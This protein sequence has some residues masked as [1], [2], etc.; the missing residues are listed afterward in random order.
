MR[1]TLVCAADGVRMSS[2]ERYRALAEAAG[3]W[4]WETDA[5]G[6]ITASNDNVHEILGFRPD[7]VI[8]KTLLDLMPEAPRDDK[9]AELEAVVAARQPFSRWNHKGL[10]KDGRV[11]SL[12]TSGLPLIDE[13]GA[14]RGYA[15]VG[16]DL[17]GAIEKLED[18]S[19]SVENERR[20]T[21]R[22][23]IDNLA[24]AIF[25]ADAATERFVDAN[26]R[27]CQ[28]LGLTRDQLLETAISD[29]DLLSAQD[30]AWDDVVEA[31]KSGREVSYETEIR[32]SSG[33]AVPIEISARGIRVGAKAYMIASVRDITERRRQQE[34]LRLK[35]HAFDS[36]ETPIALTDL[37]G[38]YT[39]VNPAF[40][41]QWGYDSADEILG[42]TP[43][44]LSAVPDAAREEVGETRERG[45]YRG[46]TFGRRKDGTTFPHQVAASVVKDDLGRPV[47][48]MAWFPILTERHRIEEMLRASRDE[49]RSLT[50]NIPG[51]VFRAS[52]DWT[53][54]LVSKCE[55]ICGY[56]DD[57][58]KSAKV[59]WFDLIHPEDRKLVS[60]QSERL[61][62]SPLHLVQEY[63]I[64]AKDGRVRWVE[65]HKTPRFDDEGRF[66][67]VDGFVLDVSE[68][69]EAELGLRRFRDVMDRSSDSILVIDSERG[70]FIDLNERACE[71]LQYSR[72]ELLQM[73]VHDVEVNIPDEKAWPAYRE[74]LRGGHST[75]L[76]GI[77]RRRDG[78][79]FPVEVNGAL[80]KYGQ[81]E[82]IVALARDISDRRQAEQELRQTARVLDE[83][84]RELNC[85]YTI[86]QLPVSKHLPLEHMF[87]RII[88]IIPEAWQY[89]QLTCARL[90][91]GEQAYETR[92]FE[93]T[94]W[95][96]RRDLYAREQKVGTLEV[97]L[98]DEGLSQ[99]KKE[100]FV[101][102]QDLL[103]AIAD[104]LG[105]IVEHK[106][107]EDELRAAN[108]QIKAKA[109]ELKETTAQLIQT[110]KLSALGQLAAGVAHEMNQPLNGIKIISQDLLGDIR[111]NR[112]EVQELRANLEDVVELVNKLAFIIDQ[113]RLFVR[114][115]EH[116]DDDTCDANEAV[117]GVLKMVGQQL[118]DHAF[119]V[120][121]DLEAALPPARA[122]LVKI[123]QVL[124]NLITN[125]RDA[126]RASGQTERRLVV[127][128]RCRADDSGN[129]VVI[130]VQDNGTGID[131]SIRDRL[132][133]PFFTTKNAGEG[134]GL[135][136]SISHRIL[137]ECGGQ[138]EIESER[139]QGAVFRVIIPAVSQP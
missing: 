123:E 13:T 45:V 138:L 58:L 118:R 114:R 29:I 60:D 109:R 81:E 93:E 105:R 136:L 28:L 98:R 4:L 15:G 9:A 139:G 95:R 70:Q 90:Q 48:M 89:P 80:M 126:V 85:L 12:E 18:V 36:S 46:E 52:A 127:R 101:S 131:P 121:T 57:E 63:R 62:K 34:Q 10:C 51:M 5:R 40:V 7:E 79:T 65:E 88:A 44:D 115:A 33:D 104:L 55:E 59:K 41:A 24:D 135:G 66:C 6:V 82:H 122:N 8:G 42:R 21:F 56:T 112:L 16:R 94:P 116:S 110:E 134:T 38:R 53:V 86:A 102:E 73:F 19:A 47:C 78:T 137:T 108:A 3:D 61:S 133:E 30:T 128:T 120:T 87:T 69:K 2:E 129:A 37:Q 35:D 1:L 107:A 74:H 96:L 97:F 132:L 100:R 32:H 76:E 124:M 20:L 72:E 67:G 22:S 84:V 54:S 91:L 49:Y 99:D 64:V 31:L 113:M 75:L 106:G 68:R 83:T 130:E 92:A 71:A 119:D 125:A 27:G 39:Y 43:F 11:V 111:K 25:I 23:L 17:K 77:H 14:F 117:G 50:S 103:N 26:E